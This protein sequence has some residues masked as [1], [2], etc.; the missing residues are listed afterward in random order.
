MTRLIAEDESCITLLVMYPNQQISE[1][2]PVCKV[3]RSVCALQVPLPMESV[4]VGVKNALVHK[5]KHCEVQNYGNKIVSSSCSEF[6][7]RSK[8]YFTFEWLSIAEFDFEA[9]F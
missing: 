6:S 8:L 1:K 5:E 9:F 2:T 7:C 3:G 4:P